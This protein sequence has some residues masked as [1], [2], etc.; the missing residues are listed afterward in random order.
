MKNKRPFIV[1]IGGTT[2]A[3]S[4]TERA[5]GAALAHAQSLGCDVEA[6]GAGAMPLES[7]DPSRPERSDEALALVAAVRRASGVIIATPSYHGGISGLVK[8]AIDF[9][10]DTREDPAPYFEGRAVGL[11]VCADGAQAMGTTLISLRAVVH[12]LRGWPTPYGATLLSSSRPF[13]NREGHGVDPAAVQ[14]CETV[15]AEVA[16]F[17]R[18]TLAAAA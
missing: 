11:I 8:N 2:R 14:A 15:G 7:Y 17:S 5:L 12:A 9:V 18:L 3:G 4:T 10:E 1:G 6:F 13:G 16:W